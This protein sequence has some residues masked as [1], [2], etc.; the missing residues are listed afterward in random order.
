MVKLL[1]KYRAD[2]TLRTEHNKT[3]ADLAGS[4]VIAKVINKVMDRR[5]GKK[6]VIIETEEG[7]EPGAGHQRINSKVM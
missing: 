6:P 4:E 1:L 2:P 3:A 7:E 5:F